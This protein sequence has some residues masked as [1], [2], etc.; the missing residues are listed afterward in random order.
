MNPYAASVLILKVRDLISDSESPYRWADST[1]LDWLNEAMAAM[2]EN[3]PEFYY[4]NSV[5]TALPTTLT[6]TVE[7]IT[8]TQT[9]QKVL[10]NYVA[11]RCLSRDNEDPETLQQAARFLEAYAMG[12]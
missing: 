12:V 4:V 9:G 8:T 10:I 5:V 1:M 3:H 2:F 6:S 11:Y 7:L